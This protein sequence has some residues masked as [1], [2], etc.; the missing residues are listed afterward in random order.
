MVN[1]NMVCGTVA[2]V[3]KG[4]QDISLTS[5]P[6]INFFRY[7]SLRHLNYANELYN[8]NLNDTA[9]FGSQ[10]FIII[11][12]VGHL[13]S[14]MNLHLKLPVLTKT[15]GTYAC[16]SDTTGYSIFSKPCELQIGGIIV[17]RMWPV[18]S[19]MR[20]E[21]STSTNKV[22]HD[23]MINKGDTYRDSLYNASKPLDLIIEMDYWFTQAYDMALPL[24]SMVNQEIRINFYFNTF[25]KMINFD[26]ATPPAPVDI[27][28]S[29]LL[30]EYI[31]LDDIILEHFQSKEHR[32]IIKQVVYNGDEVIPA[33]KTLFSTKLNFVNP[34]QELQFCCVDSVNFN[35]N[36]YFNYSRA[37]DGSPLISSAS[38]LLD[39]KH[40]YDSFL[41]ECVFRQFFPNNVYSVIPTKH[42]Y[43]MPFG[44]KPEEMNPSGSTNFGRFDEVTLS[45]KMTPNN[46]ECYLYVFAISYNIVTISNGILQMEFMNNN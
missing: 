35:N 4:I 29:S 19:D 5:D 16:W 36:N 14:K 15:S 31:F 38:L 7:K 18:C 28:S 22:G 42:Q 20:D 13:L 23:Q 45:L 17:D 3:A 21:L 44:I 12:R 33:G 8:F 46:N 32:Y 39:G 6:E 41:D 10:T 2:L 27:L 40:R 25:D 34:C 26:G 1:N 37:T 30:T 24:L 11:P 9:S 43:L